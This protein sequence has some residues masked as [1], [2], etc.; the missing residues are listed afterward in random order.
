MENFENI[1]KKHIYTGS[2]LVGHKSSSLN[3][4]AYT[5]PTAKNVKTNLKKKS[6]K[7]IKLW[8]RNSSSLDE[9]LN[10][11]YNSRL[12]IRLRQIKLILEDKYKKV[13]IVLS[14]L[15]AGFNI[16]CVI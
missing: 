10:K 7:S 2:E 12:K 13:F 15:W 6:I 3:A 9:M 4:Y 14:V 16:F 5:N 11:Y 8:F 1:R